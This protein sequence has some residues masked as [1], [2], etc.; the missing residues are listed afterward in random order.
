MSDQD[1]HHLAAAYALDA[2]DPHEWAAF[3]A[4]LASCET[5]RADVDEFRSTQSSMAQAQ[6][7]TPPPAMKRRVLDEITRT[8]QV[9]PRTNASGESDRAR[10][11]GTVRRNWIAG[12]LAAAAVLLVVGVVAF[13]GGDGTDQFAVDLAMVLEQPDAHL[14]ELAEQ[15]GT[16]GRFKVAWSDSLHRAVLI[17]DDLPPA[18]SGKAYELWL[19]TDDHSVAMR[20]LDPGNDGTVHATFDLPHSPS[21]WAITVEP[22]AGVEV[23]TG[24]II[25][26]AATS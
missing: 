12:S 1:I 14:L 25:F 10:H 24:D 15:P 26:V 2:V 21:K 8:R 17:G 5:C 6:A 9:S 3:E 4:H 7:L 16:A 13:S 18:P 23:A 19:I 11:G 20:I 22:S